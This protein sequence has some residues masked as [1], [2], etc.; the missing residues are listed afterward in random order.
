MFFI[1]LTQVVSFKST[2]PSSK[3]RVTEDVIFSTNLGPMGAHSSTKHVPKLVVPVLPPSNMPNCSI[4]D[5]HYEL[6]V[7]IELN[8][9]NT[10]LL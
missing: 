5:L 1:V 9:C 2:Y 8:Y 7:K 6:Q 3:T 4:I 10:T